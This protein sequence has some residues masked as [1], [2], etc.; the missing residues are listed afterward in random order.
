MSTSPSSGRG[1]ASPGSRPGGAGVEGYWRTLR[2]GVDAV[3]EIPPDRWDADALYD[4]DPDTPGRMNTRWG[5]F[6]DDIQGFDA[7]FFGISTREA[8][9]MDPQQRI[10][11]EVAWE[12]LEDAGIAPGSLAGSRTGVYLGAST[13]DH[14]AGL[15][16]S[17]TPADAY[18][19]TGSALSVIANRLSYCLDSRGPSM[20]VDT[21]CSSSLVAVHLACRA[22]RAGEADLALAGGVNIITSPRIALSFSQGRLMAPD[23]RCK[24][25]DHRANGYVR[26]EGAGIVVL[27]PLAAALAD[28]DRIYAVIRGGAVNQDGRTNGLAA[29]NRLAQEDVL[30]AAYADAG[31]DPAEVDYVE[32]HGTGTAVGDPIE[33]GALASVLGRGR[34]PQ[35]PLRVG[36]AKSNIGHTEAAAGVAATVPLSSATPARV[37]IRCLG[38]GERARRTGVPRRGFDLPMDP[39]GMH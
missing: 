20:I 37:A 32:A 3:R 13:Y 15:L 7:D 22:L 16:A 21:A 2:E 26:S 28:G 27:K 25:F 9:R 33:V 10:V 34:S 4:P 17:G 31:I 18:D 12:A 23:G 29:P 35:R 36:S 30:R 39:P 6:L 5:G 38:M 24:T 8:S 19:G 14:G 11:L 1:G